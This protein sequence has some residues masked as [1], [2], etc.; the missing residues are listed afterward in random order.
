MNED[1]TALHTELHNKYCELLENDTNTQRTI[2]GILDLIGEMR[3]EI[4]SLRV[5]VDKLI[6]NNNGGKV[7]GK[8]A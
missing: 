6:E 2:S 7:Y 1:I 3:G 5:D 8:S 4:K